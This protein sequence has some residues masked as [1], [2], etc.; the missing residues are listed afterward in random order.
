LWIR[1]PVFAAA[2]KN[3]RPFL[4]WTLRATQCGSKKTL[5]NIFSSVVKD[6]PLI[7]VRGFF[8]MKTSLHSG[9]GILC[10]GMKG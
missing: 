9:L 1:Q 5:N 7:K 3:R 2:N 4:F 10:S 6:L 8:Y